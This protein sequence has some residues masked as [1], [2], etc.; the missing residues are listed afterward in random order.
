[1][2]ILLELLLN[3]RRLLFKYYENANDLKYIYPLEFNMEFSYEA[4][5]QVSKIRIGNSL[6][7]VV[8]S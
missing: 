2:L 7:N 1:M 4:S 8:W 6:N 5:F 3:L